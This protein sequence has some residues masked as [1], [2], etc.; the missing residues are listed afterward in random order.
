[1]KEENIK[2]IAITA[3][4]DTYKTHGLIENF[5]K[6]IAVKNNTE[7]KNAKWIKTDK[8]TRKIYFLSAVKS[9][10]KDP[11]QNTIKAKGNRMELTPADRL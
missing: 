9:S 10:F 11:K 6:Y 3:S 1:M 2:L 5:K 4:S 8:N 7:Y